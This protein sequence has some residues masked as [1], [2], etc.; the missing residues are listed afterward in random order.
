MTQDGG[1]ESGGIISI[2]VLSEHM[3]TARFVGERSQNSKEY[4][5][6]LFHS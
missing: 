6:L 5:V 4:R 3:D 2:A 1:W